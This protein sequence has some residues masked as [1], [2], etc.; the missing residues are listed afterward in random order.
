MKLNVHL[1]FGSDVIKE[2]SD[3]KAVVQIYL[4]NESFV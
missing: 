1:I 4:Y 2:D 3:V